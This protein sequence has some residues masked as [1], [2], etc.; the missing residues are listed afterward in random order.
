MP[1]TSQTTNNPGGVTNAAPWQTMAMAGM[2]DP[3]WSQLYFD[4]FNPFLAAPYS[5]VGVGTPVVAAVAG[6]GG[7]VSLTTSGAIN[8]TTNLQLL[9][10]SYQA[11]PNKQMFFKTSFTPG[12]VIATENIY[13]GL[14][15]VGASP[16]AAADFI[17][18]T[19]AAGQTGWVFTARIGGVSTVVPLPA[20][21]VLAAS[22]PTELGFYIDRGGNIAIFWNPTTG[23]NPIS[24]SASAT[25]QPRGRVASLLQPTSGTPLAL[26]QVILAPTIGIQTT[27]AATKTMNVDFLVCIGER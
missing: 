21:C 9:L 25:G 15:P 26:T 10:A 16:L 7:L 18:F 17:G 22:T 24:A 20:S 5:T 23:N 4:D 12:A 1:L 8:D 3:T 2:P 27:S 6:L 19:C 14:F 11:T 13:A